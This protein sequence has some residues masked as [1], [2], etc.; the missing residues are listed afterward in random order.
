MHARVC[1]FYVNPDDLE[2]VPKAR[3]YTRETFK[4]CIVRVMTRHT[5]NTFNPEPS[6]VPEGA[7]SKVERELYGIS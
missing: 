5:S 4:V 1:H 3:Y 6:P 2:V 7:K